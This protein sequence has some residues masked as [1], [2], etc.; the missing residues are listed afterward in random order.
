MLILSGQN[1]S[2]EKKFRKKDASVVFFKCFITFAY[3]PTES[4]I[5]CTSEFSFSSILSILQNI[6]CL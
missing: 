6:L 5:A 2:F 1:Y 3:D 4:L